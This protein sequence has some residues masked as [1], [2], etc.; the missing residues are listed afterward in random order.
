MHFFKRWKLS[1]SIII[2]KPLISFYS[3]IMVNM[4]FNNEP[5]VFYDSTEWKSIVHYK[6]RSFEIA[7]AL[8]LTK[9]GSKRNTQ[10]PETQ[11]M[12]LNAANMFWPE[13][14]NYEGWIYK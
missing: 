2:Q 4:S 7:Q 10:N 6:W 8:E 14:Q 3:E 9:S 11:R 5:S 13:E 12:G 1:S